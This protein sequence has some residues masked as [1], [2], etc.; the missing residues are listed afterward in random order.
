MKNDDAMMGY[1]LL[2]K[3]SLFCLPNK[4]EKVDPELGFVA[5]LAVA[6]LIL[7]FFDLWGKV[8]GKFT[9]WK[10]NSKELFLE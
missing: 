10:L 2:V 5:F 1:F 6:L 7:Y 3:Y 8:W 9:A 4:Y